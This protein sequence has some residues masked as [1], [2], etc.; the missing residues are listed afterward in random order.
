MGYY[1]SPKVVLDVNSDINYQIGAIGWQKDYEWFK[2][3]MIPEKKSVGFFF[4]PSESIVISLDVDSF[5]ARSD[6]I[7]VESPFESGSLTN[8]DIINKTVNIPHGGIEF[9]LHK[10]KLREVYFRLGGYQEPM[11]VVGG[12][13]RMHATMGL[14]VR[15]GPVN[16]N[17][18]MDEAKNFTNSSQSIGLSS[19]FL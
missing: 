11:R 1:Y 10:E 16:I 5:P 8:K 3:V 19:A 13:D 9:T 4:R 15:L 17:V 12:E 6:L 18:S 7:V 14:E 2:S